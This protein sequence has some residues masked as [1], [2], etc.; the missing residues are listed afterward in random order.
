MRHARYMRALRQDLDRRLQ[1][2]WWPIATVALFSSLGRAEYAY[3]PWRRVLRNVA[4]KTAGLF[5]F[6]QWAAPRLRAAAERH[7]RDRS[8][9]IARLGREPTQEE[10]MEEH[11]RLRAERKAMRR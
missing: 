11:A 8:A 3:Q 1:S 6:G 4:F 10:A 5:A 7:K 2:I 9:L